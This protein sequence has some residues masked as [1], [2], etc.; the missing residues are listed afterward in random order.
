MARLHIRATFPLGTFLG[1]HDV[2]H[3]AE[4]PDTARLYSALVNAAGRGSTALQVDGQLRI[5]PDSAE[6]LRWLEV[7]PPTSV[8]LPATVPVARAGA[9]S[10]RAEG[11]LGKNGV[12]KQLKGQS[13]S[14]AVSGPFGWTWEEDVPEQ[15]V[16][17]IDALC[18]DVSCLGEADSPVLLDV[19]SVPP[20]HQLDRSTTA[21]PRPGDTRIRTAQPGRL[22]ALTEAH[23]QAHPRKHPTARDDRVKTDE[24][25]SPGPI[26][27]ARVRELSY[28]PVI[29]AP[30]DAPWGGVVLLH[31]L[32]SPDPEPVRMAVA[33]HQAL[34][35]RLGDDVPPIITGNYAPGAVRPANRIAVQYLDAAL[36]EHLGISG[37]VIALLIPRSAD[38]AELATLERAMAGLTRIYT[39]VGELRVVGRSRYDT[40]EFWPKVPAGRVRMWRPLP[41]LVPETRR[42]RRATGAKPW[43]LVDAA[44]LS[45][46][47]VMRDW[48]DEGERESRAA[49]VAAMRA[50]G[51]S[52][53]ETHALADSH[54]ERHAHKVPD[55]QVVFPYTALLDLG[56][57]VK[58]S[59]LLAVGQSRHLG[60]GLLV[61]E[62]ILM[63]MARARGLLP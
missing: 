23:A 11:V 21:F 5:A 44:L 36:V 54:P 34:I 55:G 35:R 17:I 20:T 43:T 56:G 7:H 37:D 31:L 39:G 62:D 1:H 58:P 18:A 40:Q 63:P 38:A 22:D 28:R 29:P 45:V 53:H 33:T 50:R 61:P 19:V 48:L 10:W 2:G 60:G 4:L 49:M 59:T 8:A 13:D 16:E 47:Y 57:L 26:A 12:K 3:R 32:G 30:P 15:I 6:A 46:A 42:Q 41:S 51:V 24:E 27:G 25:A 9:R 14:V 52:V